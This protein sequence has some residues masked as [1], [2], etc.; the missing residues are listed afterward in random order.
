MVALGDCEASYVLTGEF[1]YGLA[2]SEEMRKQNLSG[3]GMNQKVK[4]GT[5]NKA[6]SGMSELGLGI[7]SKKYSANTEHD[8]QD[9]TLATSVSIL[10]MYF[11]Y[12]LKSFYLELGYSRNVFET[13][14]EGDLDSNQE[15]AVKNIYDLE[16]GEKNSDALR[17]AIGYKV[18]QNKNFV[19]SING[20][21]TRHQSTSIVENNLG[22][23]FKLFFK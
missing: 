5:T 18:Y 21:Q 10:E 13:E 17:F 20:S 9:I 19:V 14:I 12:Y 16:E 23:D 4:L 7:G 8:G 3:S 11:T 15:T 1:G 2:S 6:G 22:L